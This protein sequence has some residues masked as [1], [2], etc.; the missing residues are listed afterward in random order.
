MD[1]ILENA[2]IANLARRFARSP[3]QVNGLQESDAE[4]IRLP[5]ADAMLAVTTDSIVEE[6]ELGLYTDPHLI[7]WM[8]VLVN[9]SDLAA[10]GAEPVGL[11]LNETLP[12][13]IAPACLDRLQR[14]IQEASAAC[15]LPVIGGDTNAGSRLHVGGTALGMIPDGRPM[16]RLGCRPGDVLLASGP[17][18]LGSCYAWAQL[19]TAAAS[20]PVAYRPAPRLRE[21]QTLRPLATACMDTSDGALAALDQ[22]MRL[23]EVGFILEPGL[24]DALHPTARRLARSLHLPPWMLLA[25][26]HGEFE[27]LFTVAPQQ[28]ERLRIEAAALGWSPLVLGAV[29]ADPGI[30]LRHKDGTTRLDTGAIR[31]LFAQYPGSVA[32][33]IRQLLNLEQPCDA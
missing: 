10:V 5:G 9:A 22:L 8:T 3:L 25:G 2:H 11:L 27:L 15:H 30:R 32:A 13:N 12:P 19:G 23:N 33:C 18:G 14:G 21:G 4:L 24:E 1:A 7:G 29:V 26:L 17:L 6:I 20:R 28:V 16:T 31:N